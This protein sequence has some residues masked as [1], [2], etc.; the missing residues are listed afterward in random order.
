MIFLLHA[1][2]IF[3]KMELLNAESSIYR[4]EEEI[5]KLNEEISK[6][7]TNEELT[8]YSMGFQKVRELIQYFE[9]YRY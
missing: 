8:R 6:M 1:K 7:P 2:K 4:S 3:A 5:K 9:T